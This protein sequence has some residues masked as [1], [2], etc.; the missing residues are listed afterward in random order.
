L[1]R[2]FLR[3]IRRQDRYQRIAGR[4]VDQQKAHQRHAD[5]NGDHIDDTPGDIGEHRSPSSSLLP[6]WE[7]VAVGGPWPPFFK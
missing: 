4:D 5:D 3:R 7:K 2:Q 6:L 1:R